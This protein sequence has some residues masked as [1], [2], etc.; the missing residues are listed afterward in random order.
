M[1][2]SFEAFEHGTAKIVPEKGLKDKLQLA[3]KEGRPL[4]VK[5]GF[6]PTAPDLHL[7]HAVVL[8][9]LKEFQDQGHTIVVILGDYTAQIGDPTG[10][11]KAR[12]PLETSQIERNVKT[13][14]DQLSKIL[15]VTKI[16]VKF[17]SEWFDKMSMRDTIKLIS[18]TTLAQIIER[19]DFKGRYE[20]GLPIAMHELLYP[21]LQGYDSVQIKSDIEIGGTDQLFNILVGRYMQEVRKQAAQVALCMPL[22]RGTDGSEKMS[23]SQNNYVGLTERPEEMYGKIM[24]IPDELLQEYIDLTTSFTDD[25]KKILKDQLAAGKNPMEVK[26]VIAGNVVMQYHSVAAATQA[27]EF[28]RKQVQSRDLASKEHKYVSLT[29]LNLPAV[30]LSLIEL[31]AALEK[32]KSKSQVRELIR[33]GS[34]TVDGV[35]II[36]IH[37]KFAQFTGDIQIKIGKRNFYK[38]SSGS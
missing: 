16:K 20:K 13:Y 37:H 11:N 15:D 29:E 1:E 14:L 32:G 4:I 31:C 38:V 21:I 2:H 35:K 24:S 12:P 7:G 3:L 8:K 25:E 22:L 34:V 19:N 6:D 27:E 10:K 5:L 33:A 30:D 18:T 26:K 17:N 36:D 28:F 9:K 23:K